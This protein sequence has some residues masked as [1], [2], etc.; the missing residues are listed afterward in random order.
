MQGLA[1]LGHNQCT[2]MPSNQAI[3]YPSCGARLG[4]I[5]MYNYQAILGWFMM[6]H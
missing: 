4:M 3:E 6:L 1:I 5:D 2:E